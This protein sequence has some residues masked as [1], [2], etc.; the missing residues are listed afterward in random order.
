[1]PI[2]RLVLLAVAALAAVLLPATAAGAARKAPC[3]PGGDGPRCLVW[4]GKVLAVNDGDTFKVDLDGD[5]R[6]RGV[7]VRFAAVQAMELTVHHPNPAKRRD[8]CHGIEATARVE[9]FV[10]ASGKRVRLT[11]EHAASRSDRRLARHVAIRRD[12]RWQDL[13]AILMA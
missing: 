8:E 2:R 11:A 7:D 1:M 10:K 3:L 9:Q 12:G 4:T 6:R 13:G 5:G